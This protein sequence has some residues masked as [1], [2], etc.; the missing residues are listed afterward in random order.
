MPVL[1][2][3]NTPWSEISEFEAGLITSTDVNEVSKGLRELMGACVPKRRKMSE[4]ARKI[5]TSY[6]SHIAAKKMNDVYNYA[7]RAIGH[8]DW[9]I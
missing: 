4:A 3:H 6:S 1:T 7:L 8:S 2:T 9:I 5:S